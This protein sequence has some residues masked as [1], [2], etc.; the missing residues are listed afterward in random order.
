MAEFGL[1]ARNNIAVSFEP[2]L[3]ILSVV[4]YF[5][6]RDKGVPTAM[7]ISLVNFF[8]F[9]LLIRCRSDC[10]SSSDDDEDESERSYFC[11]RLCGGVI[12][13]SSSL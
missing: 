7:V 13:P 4:R 10:N 6:P 2:A 3:A 1:I 12:L 11:R 9:F 8:S 5:R